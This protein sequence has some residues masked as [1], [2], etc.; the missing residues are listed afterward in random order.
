MA[1]TSHLSRLLSLFSFE[2]LSSITRS[3]GTAGTPPPSSSSSPFTSRIQIPVRDN[4]LR[5]DHDGHD[6]QRR[7]DRGLPVS[8]PSLWK[9]CPQ[10]QHEQKR[11]GIDGREK[12]TRL[13][14]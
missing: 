9:Q 5:I 4:V 1:Q 12:V 13:G 11:V 7:H 6:H 14:Q 3:A 2:A 10:S 8:P